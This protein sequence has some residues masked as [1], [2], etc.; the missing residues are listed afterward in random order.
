MSVRV[1]PRGAYLFVAAGMVLA[2]TAPVRAQESAGQIPP[3]QTQSDSLI[4][5]DP[6]APLPDLGVAWPDLDD[7]SD[8]MID[9]QPAPETAATGPAERR[10]SVR[11]DGIDEVKS[12][13]LRTRFDELSVLKKNDGEPANGAQIDRRA[14][15]DAE[16]LQQLLRAEGYYDARVRP[17][18]E[19]AGDRLVVTLRTRLGDIY[20]LSDVD[21]SGVER[22]GDRTDELTAAFGVDQQDPA[23]ADNI[24]AGEEA[25]RAEAGRQ[26]FP[27]RQGRGTRAGRRSRESHRAAEH[28]GRSR[29]AAALR[30]DPHGQ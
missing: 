2:G 12:D 4:P 9:G 15:E 6:L 26:G 5:S 17:L 18:V 22:A 14:R 28:H 30:H 20:Q 25:L 23:N 10:Y 27:L 1:L 21:I 13:L 11:L 16:L 3:A 24:V 19:P 8:E 7:R 29:H